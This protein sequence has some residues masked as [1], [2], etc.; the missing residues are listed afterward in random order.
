[1]ELKI[2]KNI[3]VSDSGFV[4]NPL[5]GDSYSLNPI[6]V[7]IFKMLQKESEI[8]EIKTTILDTY[9]TDETTFEKDFYD[10][11]KKLAD[12]KLIDNNI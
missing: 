2:K 3:A 10:F 6:G 5:T 7:S 12:L 4:F 11:T 9:D 1:M 8:E